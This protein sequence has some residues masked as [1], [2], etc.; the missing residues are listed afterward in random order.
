MAVFPLFFAFVVYA[1]F[2]ATFFYLVAFT[3]DLPVPKTIDSGLVGPMGE[4]IA[5]DIA[6]LGLFAAQHSI[7]ARRGFKRWWTR[8]VPQAVERSTY[9]LAATL[10]LA[11]LAWQWQPI[12]EPVLWSVTPFFPPEASAGAA[13]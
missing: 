4:A 5:V 12:P 1:V 8:F 11:L 3:G 9:V 13:L 2:A 6:L 7:M 10:A